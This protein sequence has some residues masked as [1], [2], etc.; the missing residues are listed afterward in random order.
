MASIVKKLSV[1]FKGRKK[2]TISFLLPGRKKVIEDG[3]EKLQHTLEQWL[4]KR[5]PQEFG[6]GA[7]CV[8]L[9]STGDSEIS[10]ENLA[11]DIV[12]DQEQGVA[13]EVLKYGPLQDAELQ[14][15]AEVKGGTGVCSQLLQHI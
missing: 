1:L 2:Q 6:H 9:D 8:L 5:V 10:L 11:A 3:A 15:K 7:T 12:S 13:D 4:D 14:L